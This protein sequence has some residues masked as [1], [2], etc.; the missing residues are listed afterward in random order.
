M[1]KF[2]EF[3]GLLPPEPIR[4]RMNCQG[5]SEHHHTKMIITTKINGRQIPSAQEALVETEETIHTRSRWVNF[6]A[7]GNPNKYVECWPRLD[8]FKADPEEDNNYV[9][10][11]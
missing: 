1:S 10:Q 5:Q 11:I 2:D 8:S 6:A 7:R 9:Y 3:S 4:R